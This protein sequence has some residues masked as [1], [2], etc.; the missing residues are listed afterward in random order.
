M[1]PSMA[2]EF[3]YFQTFHDQTDQSI[4]SG[5]CKHSLPKQKGVWIPDIPVFSFPESD[6]DTKSEMIS[7]P[8]SF[9]C[10]KRWK[11]GEEIWNGSVTELNKFWTSVLRGVRMVRESIFGKPRAVWC[12]CFLW[13]Q[14]LLN[15]CF[16]FG[17]VL[18]AGG[19]KDS[20]WKVQEELLTSEGGSKRASSSQGHNGIQKS[21][22]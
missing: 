21:S 1:P 15:I 20:A 11:K 18:R 10:V 13:N 22:I 2:I 9:L 14:Y 3:V 5:K 4:H 12:Y 16:V 17:S 6:F 19:N 7:F 8:L